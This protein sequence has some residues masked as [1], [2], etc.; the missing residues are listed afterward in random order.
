MQCHPAPPNETMA[1]QNVS[2]KLGGRAESFSFSSALS[3]GPFAAHVSLNMRTVLSAALL[4]ACLGSEASACDKNCET[5]IDELSEAARKRDQSVAQGKNS[6]VV[7]Q[8]GA[9]I[10]VLKCRPLNFCSLQLQPGE[11]PIED[12]TLGDSTL[13]DAEVR[14]SGSEA[15]PN[16]RV[17]IKPDAKATQTSLV[18]AT[19]R[20]FFDVQLLKSDTD[21]TTVLAFTYPQDV[22]AANKARIAKLNAAKAASAAAARKKT[23]A[24]RARKSVTVDK[25]PVYVGKLD[26]EYSITGRTKFKP[27]RVFN[28]GRKTYVDLPEGFQGERPVFLASGTSSSDEIVNSR[29]SGNRL[30]IDRVVQA[31]TLVQGVGGRA[32]K[33]KIIRRR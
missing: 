6:S 2:A 18:V 11:I 13:W 22:E 27:I 14:V 24:E 31:G 19:D 29:W 4:V 10:P 7:V 16:V 26:F 21:Y 3:R 20:R 28:D 17:L 1:N 23:K 12:I 32:Q 33:I 5:T 30:T 25:K 15:N 9:G 8:Y